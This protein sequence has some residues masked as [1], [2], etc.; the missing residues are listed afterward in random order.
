MSTFLSNFTELSFWNFDVK[1][2]G[3]DEM[4]HMGDI[5]LRY[6]M[7]RRRRR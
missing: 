6:G 4:L 3:S 5:V 7:E 1:A 2:D